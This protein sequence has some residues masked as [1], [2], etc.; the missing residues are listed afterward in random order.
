MHI[1]FLEFIVSKFRLNL[2]FILLFISFVMTKN[3]NLNNLYNVSKH[4]IYT[5]FRS[6]GKTCSQENLT[7]VWQ[8]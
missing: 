1:D 7:N 4:K 6:K 3:K 8:N 5:G 2:T